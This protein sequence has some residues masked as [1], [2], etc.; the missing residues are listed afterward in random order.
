M[1]ERH[2]RLVVDRKHRVAGELLEQAVLDHRLAAAAAL[3]GRLEDEVHRTLEVAALAQH[4]GG[5]QQHG[6]VA[7]VAAGMHAAGVLRAMLEVV[8]LVH[9]QAVHVG[10]QADRL[11]R[12]ALAQGSHQAGLAE[13]ARHF[14][15]PL[16]ELGGDDVG[17]AVLLVSKLRMGVDV[18]ADGGDLTVDF[19]TARH[20]GHRLLQK[21][22]ERS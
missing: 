15:A 12:V 2:A 13:A 17:G 8:G 9:R 20:N 16:L 19:K 14:E 7:V 11:H 10:A 3:L 1:A 21:V 5:A 6:R 18:A 22:Y 4:L